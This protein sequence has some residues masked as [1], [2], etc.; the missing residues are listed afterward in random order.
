MKTERYSIP[1]KMTG[2]HDLQ[3]K[4]IIDVWDNVLAKAEDF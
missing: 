3:L 1:K 2:F 4:A